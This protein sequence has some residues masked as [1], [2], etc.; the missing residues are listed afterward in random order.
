MTPRLDDGAEGNDQAIRSGL[1]LPAARPC[2][3]SLREMRTRGPSSRLRA[4]VEDLRATQRI[5]Q[6]QRKLGARKVMA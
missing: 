6:L 2:R 5:D 1:E 4:I 3:R